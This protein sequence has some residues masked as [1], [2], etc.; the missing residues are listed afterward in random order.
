MTPTPRPISR[1]LVVFAAYTRPGEWVTASTLA[2]RI[3]PMGSAEFAREVSRKLSNL[4][5]FGHLERRVGVNPLEHEYL[6]PRHWPTLAQ[7]DL[8]RVFGIV[9]ASETT[10]EEDLRL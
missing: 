4:N 8:R 3:L 6:R 10:Y 2:T 7:P 1:F 9:S 5:R